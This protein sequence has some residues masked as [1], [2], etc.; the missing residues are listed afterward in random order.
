MGPFRGKAGPGL[1]GIVGGTAGVALAPA[2]LSFVV[3]RQVPTPV[4]TS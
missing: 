3:A 2:P 4:P 1:S